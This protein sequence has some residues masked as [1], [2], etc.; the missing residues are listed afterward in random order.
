MDERIFLNQG[1]YMNIKLLFTCFILITLTA[2]ERSEGEGG[3]ATIRGKVFVQDFNSSGDLRNEY[4]GAEREV[5]IVYG[6]DDFYGDN[7]DTHYDGSFR[8]DFLRTGRYR[9]FAYSECN[10][11]EIPLAPV[12]IDTM[13]TER[14]QI[15]DVGEI[16]VTE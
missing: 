14:D 7:I 9:V 13:I 15:V 6:D 12:I 1:I 11:C 3:S 5:Y 16:V 10:N 2:C 4:C 8:F